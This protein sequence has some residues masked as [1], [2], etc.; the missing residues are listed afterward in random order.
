MKWGSNNPKMKLDW[1]WN[2]PQK[3]RGIESGCNIRNEDN[4]KDKKTWLA[5]ETRL[6]WGEHS[7]HALR[8]CMKYKNPSNVDKGHLKLMEYTKMQPYKTKGY[9]QNT[10]TQKP[11]QTLPKKKPFL[12]LQEHIN[13]GAPNC[14][15]NAIAM[16][17]SMHHPYLILDLIFCSLCWAQTA[18]FCPSFLSSCL[19]VFH[20]FFSSIHYLGH[21]GSCSY[22]LTA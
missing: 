5:W 10:R 21:H 20:A 13:N 6:A 11:K 4:Y 22:N 7:W 2:Q 17:S 18:P 16:V 1:V 12:L 14:S 9:T 15:K 8:G 19:H 3:A